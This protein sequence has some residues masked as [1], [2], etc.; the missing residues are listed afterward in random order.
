MTQIFGNQL[1]LG[2]MFFFNWSLFIISSDALTL[3][4]SLVS[5]FLLIIMKFRRVVY[6]V[7]KIVEL[8]ISPKEEFKNL[9]KEFRHEDVEE[10]KLKE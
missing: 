6:E 3:T 1:I 10:I 5:M 9:E 7:Y 2:F 4:C 8:L